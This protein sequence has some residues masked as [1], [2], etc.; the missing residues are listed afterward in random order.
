MDAYSSPEVARGKPASR[1][2]NQ[3]APQRPLVVRR[4]Q[5]L[6]AFQN[7]SRSEVIRTNIDVDKIK[8]G[9][10]ENERKLVPCPVSCVLCLFAMLSLE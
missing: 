7:Q 1:G 9:I 10:S 4:D 6:Q 2:V 5:K 3:V 8:N